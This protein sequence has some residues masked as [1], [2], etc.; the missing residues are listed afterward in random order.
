MSFIL[1]NMWP[2]VGLAFAIGLIFGWTGYV[3]KGTK[4]VPNQKT[5]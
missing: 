2:Y 5:K 3:E 4:K 1:Q